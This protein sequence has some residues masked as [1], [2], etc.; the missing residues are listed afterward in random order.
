MKRITITGLILALAAAALGA[1]EKKANV[2]WQAAMAKE[3]V[4]GDLKGAVALYESAV[5]EAGS[6]RALAAKALLKV[7]ECYQKLGEDKAQVAYERVA[8]EFAD[9]KEPA[10]EARTRLASLRG[11]APA[12]TGIVTR[13][14]WAG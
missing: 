10:A 11:V 7:A 1:D 3:T 5:K 4:Q 13:Q 2:L 8:R 14:G 12:K 9:Q 6:N